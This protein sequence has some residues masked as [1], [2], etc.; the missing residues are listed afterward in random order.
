MKKQSGSRRLFF[1]AIVRQIIKSVVVCHPRKELYLLISICPFVHT[2]KMNLLFVDSDCYMV[3]GI[4]GCNLFQ[5]FCYIIF[6]HFQCAI[7]WLFRYF[8]RRGTFFC[9]VDG[10]FIRHGEWQSDS[11]QLRRNRIESLL[12]AYS[13]EISIFS[14]SNCL[15]R[16]SVSLWM[17]ANMELV[18]CNSSTVLSPNISCYSNG[19]E[20]D[21]R[22]LLTLKTPDYQNTPIKD[23]NTAL[24]LAT[25]RLPLVIFSGRYSP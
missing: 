3:S 22:S 25:S 18:F 20:E 24:F 13:M 5:F 12:Y 1:F 23:F 6:V 9:E 11:E 17:S 2:F 8:N 21:Y 14:V 7:Q 4:Y 19:T 15:I 10:I 16:L